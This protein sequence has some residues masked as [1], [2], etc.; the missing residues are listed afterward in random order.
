VVRHP[1][2]LDE[3]VALAHQLV[4]LA[5]QVA[6]GFFRHRPRTQLKE[7]GT[8]VSQADLAVQQQ[9]MELLARLRPDDRVLSEEARDRPNATSVARWSPPVDAL[10]RFWPPDVQTYEA[11]F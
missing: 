4:D 8:P 9:L 10:N 2:L 3:E 7:D 5:S 1:G 6:V 11:V